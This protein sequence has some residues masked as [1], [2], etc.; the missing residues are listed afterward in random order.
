VFDGGGK[1]FFCNL[2]PSVDGGFTK[3][4]ALFVEECFE[5]ANGQKGF[6]MCDGL[7]WLS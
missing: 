3:E 4:V 1:E 5:L 6:S 7:L 2:A